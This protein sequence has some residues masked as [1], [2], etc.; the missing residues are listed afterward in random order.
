VYLW[1]GYRN[2]Y[3]VYDKDGNADTCSF[4]VFVRSEYQTYTIC[5]SVT[6]VVF[7]LENK[8]HCSS[9]NVDI[10]YWKK[11]IENIVKKY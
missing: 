7:I 8:V 6:L 11:T 3:V 4:E 9:H 1:G 10:V 2:T 5:L